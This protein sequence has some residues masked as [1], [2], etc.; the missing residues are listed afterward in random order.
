MGHG[1]WQNDGHG[2]SDSGP[3]PPQDHLQGVEIYQCMEMFILFFCFP[4]FPLVA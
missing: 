2:D 1:G 3:P 4:Y